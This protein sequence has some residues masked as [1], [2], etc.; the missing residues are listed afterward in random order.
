MLWEFGLRKADF[1]SLKT[2]VNYFILFKAK[3]AINRLYK[4]RGGSS[5]ALTLKTWRA[6]QFALCQ[7]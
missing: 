6:V 7:S 2:D 4:K 3:T 1:G 5:F